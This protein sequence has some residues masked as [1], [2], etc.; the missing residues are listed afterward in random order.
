MF[1]TRKH[2]VA[3]NETEATDCLVETT[4]QLQPG[5]DGHGFTFKGVLREFHYYTEVSSFQGVGM[6]GFH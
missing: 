1:I 2:G 4:I 5:A 6:R 3:Y